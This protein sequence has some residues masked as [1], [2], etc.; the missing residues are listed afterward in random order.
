MNDN[1]NDF[2]DDIADDLQRAAMSPRIAMAL[3]TCQI[4]IHTFF[5]KSY[6]GETLNWLFNMMIIQTFSF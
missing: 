2:E 3:A 5:W 6:G 1:I 4:T